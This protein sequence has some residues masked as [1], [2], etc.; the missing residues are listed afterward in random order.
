MKMSYNNYRQGRNGNG[1]S[2]GQ[3]HG[4]HGYGGGQRSGGGQTYVWRVS[5]LD[6]HVNR[7]YK[8]FRSRAQALIFQAQ[9]ESNPNNCCVW[10]DKWEG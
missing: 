9:V 10:I 3:R 5:W 4:G 1:R 2:G 6:K 7:R 8:A